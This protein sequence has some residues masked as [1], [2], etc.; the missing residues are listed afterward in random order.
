MQAPDIPA[1]VLPP[2]QHARLTSAAA[3]SDDAR[4]YAYFMAAAA[5]PGLRAAA[6]HTPEFWKAVEVIA[7]DHLDF[8]KDARGFLDA[9]VIASLV[10]QTPRTTGGRRS[11]EREEAASRLPNSALS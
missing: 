1:G 5:C 11:T 7:A 10:S 9:V 8:K 3:A 2:A 4:R 6:E